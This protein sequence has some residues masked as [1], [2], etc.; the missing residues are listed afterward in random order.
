ME[1]FLEQFTLIESAF[2]GGFLGIAFV[3]VINVIRIIFTTY[4]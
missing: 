1:Q 3:I 2:I 4:K